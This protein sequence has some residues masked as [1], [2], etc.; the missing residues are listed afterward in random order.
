MEIMI[1]AEF[2]FA[3]LDFSF[4]SAPRQKNLTRMAKLVQKF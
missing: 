2:Q 4:V 1:P 3:F